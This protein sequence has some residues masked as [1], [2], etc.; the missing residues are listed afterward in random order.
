M[1]SAPVRAHQRYASSSQVNKMSIV[2]TFV[3]HVL[4]FAPLLCH[5]SP[6]VAWS[7]DGHKIVC[8]VAWDEL[9][10]AALD[11]VETVLDVKSKQQFAN[12]CTW[13]DEIRASR[14]YTASWHF[15]N[16][17][18]DATSVDLDRDC[19]GPRSCVVAQIR[20]DA[21]ALAAKT[22]DAGEALKFLAHFVGD[23]HQ[24]LHVSFED[25]R[26]GNEVRGTFYKKKTNLHAV[27]DTGIIDH[28]GRTWQQIADD[29]EAHVTPEERSEWSAS[30]P[31]DW[32]DES[33]AITL[34][35]RTRYA[36]HPDAFR[37]GAA[38]ENR[39]LPVVLKRLQ[40]AGVRLGKTLNE[41][42]QIRLDH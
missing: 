14:P 24:P 37:L 31:L 23:V 3:R 18:R 35:P 10:A 36:S 27:W 40:M 26:G 16:V 25:D 1:D 17:P 2:K 6:A 39:N 28:D 38:Y 41:I 9:N 15:L 20:A 19:S 34:A 21:A 32:A 12:L 11:H 42:Y 13:A 30:R 29:L 22:G 5:V 7:A 4:L 33:L 8:A